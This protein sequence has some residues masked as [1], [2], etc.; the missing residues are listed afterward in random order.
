L[1]GFLLGEFWLQK[2]GIAPIKNLAGIFGVEE[3]L[4]GCVRSVAQRRITGFAVVFAVVN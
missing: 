4:T 3:H 2:I 1:A